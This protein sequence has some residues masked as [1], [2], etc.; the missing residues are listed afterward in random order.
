[1][2]VESAQAMRLSIMA[3]RLVCGGLLRD[4]TR[5]TG[6]RANVYYFNGKRT[7]ISGKWDDQIN[8]PKLGILCE[9]DKVEPNFYISC[10]VFAWGNL[11][12]IRGEI[13]NERN[14]QDNLRAIVQSRDP[15]SGNFY[16]ER[17]QPQQVM[18]LEHLV[19]FSNE[20]L[21]HVNECLKGGS[22]R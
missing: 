5:D 19:F 12:A 15:F 1:M 18:S 20:T 21:A 13:A 4:I 9:W 3:W 16:Y 7:T 11:L 14:P 2:N 10:A 17:I 6:D 22:S 8:K